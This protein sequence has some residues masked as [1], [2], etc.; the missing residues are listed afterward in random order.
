MSA[1]SVEVRGVGLDPQTRCVHYHTAADV[2]AIKMK[3]CGLYYA[4]KACHEALA[5]HEIEVWPRDQRMQKAVLC[6]SCRTELTIND[7]MASEHRC[8]ACGAEFNP[9]C[10]KH[11]HFYFELPS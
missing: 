6:G 1:G 8:P 7:Y 11:Y 10:R 4:C 3:C 5:E 2:I 9:G